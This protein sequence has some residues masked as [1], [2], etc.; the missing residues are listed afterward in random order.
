MPNCGG[1]PGDGLLEDEPGRGDRRSPASPQGS[2]PGSHSASGAPRHG[3]RADALARDD[4]EPDRSGDGREPLHRV[5]LGEALPSGVELE[6]WRPVVGYEGAYEV[7]NLG[8]LRS[9]P[10]TTP[11]KNGST[12]TAPGLLLHPWT[13]H[14]GRK[15]VGL[16][17]DGKTRSRTVRW[18]V[19]EAFADHCRNDP[20]LEAPEDEE[21]RPV[22]GYE[23]QYL[24][25]DRGRVRS[26]D[27][28]VR[29]QDGVVQPKPRRMLKLHVKKS[30]HIQVVF[31]KN[32]HH[33]SPYV[34]KLVLE[35]FVGP[36]PPGM[37]AC[38]WD[39]NPANNHVDN[40]RWDTRSANGLD[41]VR[42]GNHNQANKVTCIRGHDLIHPN[43]MP[44]ATPKGYR[45]C[46]A[47]N[48]GHGTLK[49][50]RRHGLDLDIQI[51][52]DRHYYAIMEISA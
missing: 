39:G 20:S 45:A 22:L 33:R 35:A 51:E 50:A 29:R 7:S 44:S 28:T 32:N 36:R 38:H 6:E 24:V 21:W 14:T 37:E 16:T 27:R 41:R 8:R 26:V 5:P 4:V 1:G 19:Q 3:V 17:K 25:S 23:T 48:R 34:H 10:R 2:G 52:S 43:L 18:L 31:S 46:L 9:L 12:R 15:L 11:A 47:C 49:W 13:T 42:H 30:G 40:L